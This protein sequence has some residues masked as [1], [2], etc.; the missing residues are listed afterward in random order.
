MLDLCNTW[1]KVVLDTVRHM[2]NTQ[3]L[4]TRQTDGP[5]AGTLSEHHGDD[6]LCANAS[7][8]FILG[9]VKLGF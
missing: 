7:S 4:D 2:S 5:A 6:A 8:F 3:V 9:D 1:P